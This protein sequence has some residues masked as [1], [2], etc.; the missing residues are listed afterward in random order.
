MRATTIL[1]LLSFFAFNLPAQD[2]CQIRVRLHGYSYD[3][4]WFG[5]TFGKR[6]E[7]A[8]FGLRQ[9]DGFYELQSPQPLSPGMYAI[10]H[11]R[12]PNTNFQF[13]N[14]WLPEGQRKF[15]IETNATFP[16]QNPTIDGSQENELFFRYQQQFKDLD[17][18]LDS[19]IDVWR[20]VQDEA[21]FRNR[22]KAEEE[23]RQMQEDF[24]A[25]HP[26][27]MTAGLVRQ[28]LF[29]IPPKMK[30]EENHWQQE[31]NDR[32]LWQRRH[33][34]DQMDLRSENFLK[35]P[36]WIERTDFFLFHLPP[37]NPDSAKVLIDEVLKNLEANPEAYRYY[38][39]YLTNSLARMSQFQL[40]EVFVYMVRNYVESGKA[41]W[42]D[43]EDLQKYIADARRMEP[44]FVGKKTPDI[45]LY[46]R[47]NNPVSLGSIEAPLTLMVFWLPDCSH[48]RREMPVV[49]N[50]W[51]NFQSKGLKVVSV[52][53]KYGS[54]VPACWE[55]ADAQ[56]MPTEWYV[57]A[58]PPR[59][60]NMAI[61]FNLCTFPRIFLLDAQKNIVFKRAGEMTALEF[62]ATIGKFLTPQ[63]Q[64]NR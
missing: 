63:K 52:C 46:D 14:I 36:Q 56:Q 45:T 44:L 26:A 1:L 60:S 47:E 57:L 16:Y 24:L 49:K 11:R 41:S 5:Q 2:G 3:T 40:D 35:Y 7:V 6:A 31:A 10:I 54:D 18:R 43:R 28:T 30:N 58:D 48:C 4:L 32:W 59:R 53:G 42:V 64:G 50:V 8:F 15:S 27:S 17:D 23:M 13:F 38:Q 33:Y 25:K 29:P 21:S 61:L 39:K 55:F 62:E 12:N 51:E 37:P 20:Y 22:V 34:F 19:L 9:N